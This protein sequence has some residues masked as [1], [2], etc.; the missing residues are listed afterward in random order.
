[1]AGG[2]NKFDTVHADKPPYLP[3]Q[4]TEEWL[5]FL[6]RRFQDM[7]TNR[8]KSFRL[9]NNRSLEQYWKDSEQRWVSYVPEKRRKSWQARVVKPITRNR[10]IGIIAMMLNSLS[11]PNVFAELGGENN[12]EVAKAFDDL[13]ELSQEK[14]HYE[15]K[16][17]MALVDAV[18]M[19][20][21]FIQEDY[22]SMQ[23][24][25]EDIIS[26]DPATNEFESKPRTITDFEGMESSIVSPYEVYLGNIF[27][28][29]IQ[30]QP[31]LFRRTVV[32][33][34]QAEAELGLFEDFKYVVAGKG[35]H[36]EEDGA[37]EKFF[38]QAQ[39]TRDMEDDSV[40]ILRYWDR[41][42]DRI[43]FLAN[44]VLLTP[45][46]MPIP[47]IHKDYNLVPLRF[48]LFSN[49]FFYGKSLPDKLM[50]EQDV[51][52]TMYRMMIDKTFLSIFP[53]MFSKGTGRVSPNVIVP[54]KMTPV[55][56][57]MEIVEVPGVSGGLGNEFSMLG[58][59]ESSMNESS[60]SPQ[61]LGTPA[62][63]ERSAT[64]VMDVRRGAE[65]LIGLFGF[66]IAFAVEDLA[67]LR[68]QNI[69]QFWA[70]QEPLL[71]RS[72]RGQE[73]RNLFEVRDA[74][75][76]DDTQGTRQIK[77][78]TPAATPTGNEIFKQQGELRKQGKNVEIIMLDPDRIR[79]YKIFAR[80]KAAPK[81]R[82]S[83]ALKKALGIEFYDRFIENPLMSPDKVTRDAIRLWDKNPD[84][85]MK[86]QQE[87]QQ[88]QQPPQEE[89]SKPGT[90]RTGNIASNLAAAAQ[91]EM[92]ALI[93]QQ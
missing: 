25:V 65:Q 18:S 84:D 6:S 40:E 37:D 17:L 63:G 4:E 13:L 36:T 2:I 52:D 47:Y 27:E 21:A 73:V 15:L 23:R 56:P 1:M 10:C 51:I 30:K 69:L 67:N 76:A 39:D 16:Y 43:A 61:L 46:R 90:Q 79:D 86:S 22:V 92:Q 31:D 5:S 60:I 11:E 83:P 89:A 74:T 53:P 35:G 70:K 44:G 41:P 8:S 64:Q 77:F 58:A 48:E 12:E 33:Y 50:W 87:L 26:W 34:S 32:P 45:V 3:S 71:S 38:Y 28:P 81:D 93:Q 82:M 72:G 66:M 78:A 29:D 54:G 75:L 9:L 68:I 55:S 80:V 85:L 88:Q 62:T 42:N 20:T 7:D 91:P 14:D 24:E 57:D 59:L 49:R 19:G